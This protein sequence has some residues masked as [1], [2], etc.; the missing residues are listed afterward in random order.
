ML[1]MCLKCFHK[2]LLLMNSF[3][4]CTLTHL[5]APNRYLVEPKN[6]ISIS[7]KRGSIE[8]LFRLCH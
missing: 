1:N 4:S 8:K 6:R 7:I 2:N 5:Q 3:K